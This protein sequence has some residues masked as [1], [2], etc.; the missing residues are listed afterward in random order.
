MIEFLDSH[1]SHLSPIKGAIF[2]NVVLHR[3]DVVTKELYFFKKIDEVFVKIDVFH[4]SEEPLQKKRSFC[5][6]LIVV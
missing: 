2:E 4:I 1:F 6:E 5:S 3:K